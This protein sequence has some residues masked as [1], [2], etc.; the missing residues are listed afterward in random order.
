MHG[1]TLCGSGA[2]TPV[3][4]GQDTCMQHV[5]SSH[6]CMLQTHSCIAAGAAATMCWLQHTGTSLMHSPFP[7]QSAQT[8]HTSA[9]EQIL[10]G[11]LIALE[12]FYIIV[13]TQ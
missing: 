12:S 7:R 13:C 10:P 9:S 8:P 11:L 4:A 6:P 2:R 1:A 5:M 3:Y